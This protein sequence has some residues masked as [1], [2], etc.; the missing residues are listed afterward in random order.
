M[1]TVFKASELMYVGVSPKLGCLFWRVYIGVPL[2]RGN[3]HVLSRRYTA[4]PL[5]TWLYL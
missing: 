1:S 3:Y 5:V 2:F 4:A